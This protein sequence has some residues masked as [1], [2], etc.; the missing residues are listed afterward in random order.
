MSLVFLRP[1][2]QHD[3]SLISGATT[4]Q[5][6]TVQ[7]PSPSVGNK[8]S[9]RLRC[10]GTPLAAVA[11]DV[12]LQTSGSPYGYSEGGAA[13]VWRRTGDGSTSWR[14][15]TDTPTLVEVCHPIA[16]DSGHRNPSTP[17]ELPDGYMGVMLNAT[18]SLEAVY[19]HRISSAWVDSSTASLDSVAAG[20]LRPDFVVMPSGRLMG[21][22]GNDVLYSDDYGVTWT[23]LSGQN[24]IVALGTDDVMCVEVIG[25]E[26]VM[27]C[28][29]STG[30]TASKVAVSRDGGFTFDLA[31]S[32]VTMTNPRTCVLG[33]T[34]YVS[35]ISG[36]SVFVRPV[37][38]G[39]GLGTAVSTGV[40]CWGTQAI[41]T[42]DDGTLWV[43][44]WSP[45]S[46]GN[47]KMS[48]AWSA[49]GVTWNTSTTPIDTGFSGVYASTGFLSL[50]AGMWRD[51]MVVLGRHDSTFG[52]DNGI[53]AL[54]FGQYSTW[55]ETG[56]RT[57]YL[58][59]DYP[60]HLNW[61]ATTTG[62]GATITNQP[63]LRLVSTAGNGTRYVAGSAIWSATSAGAH[64]TIKMRLRVNSGGSLA[65][66]DC[67]L[68]A[69]IDDGVNQQGITVRF[70]TTGARCYNTAGTQIGA[71]LV[72]DL[73]QWTDFVIDFW[74]DYS[75][76]VSGRLTILYAQAGWDGKWTAWQSGATVAE[77]AG[78]AAGAL[79]WRG[80]NAQS[81]D[82]AFLI[83]GTPATVTT[84]PTG[85]TGRA[86]STTAD[87]WLADGVRLGAYGAGG[88]SADTYGVATRYTYGAD[89][90]WAELRPSR[91]V[92]STADH[93]IW[94]WT[95]D[96][97]SNDLF[98]GNMIAVFGTNFRAASFQ[99]D[100][101]STFASLP[102]N[103][104][105]SADLTAFTISSGG[106]GYLLASA[107]VNWR[108]GQFKSNGDSRRFFVDIG[109]A[110]YEI[111][112]NDERRLYVSNVDLSAASGTATI[113]GD[114]MAAILPQ[115]VQYRYQRVYVGSQYT[116]DGK[117]HLG[118]PVFDRY[119]AP[120]QL[121]DFGFVDRSEP[122][123]TTT[124]AD[125]GASLS[126]RRR[127]LLDTLS[128]QW[129]PLNRLATD[130]E[131]RIADMYRALEGSLRPV[132]L[133]R[134][135][136]DITTLSLVQVREVLTRT[137]VRGEGADALTRIDQLLLREVW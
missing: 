111:E 100:T 21:Y 116:A 110:V 29:S 43:F 53:S 128:I 121:Y 64:R 76:G 45:T 33:G 104:P 2:S 23:V 78:V 16:Y 125:N 5:G 25:D 96:A 101:A 97:G 93:A 112:D 75:A 92:R 129:P 19:F 50:S 102:V 68:Q 113:F 122:N 9:L 4:E 107:A 40:S 85:L 15:Y 79:Q 46:G 74:H 47:M 14:G 28:A 133:W 94:S 108:Q 119:F 24:T 81:A 83:V 87:V 42:R 130:V 54:V 30:A 26:V 65:S 13:M 84:N 98:R 80:Q 11:A 12:M 56:V 89:N 127:P 39:G 67:C 123:V 105:M 77:Q 90:A 55:P 134:D 120:E 18:P 8:G 114:R 60:D 41:A 126:Y 3:S 35:E 10:S 109:S 88:V 72:A 58:P 34:V 82:L 115:F 118:T 32:A 132:V 1:T 124:D 137:N 7:E 37:I 52:S 62:G 136:G 86:L 70:T 20:A 103:V 131:L 73:T 31:D 36:T 117:Y 57:G 17:R 51:N 95:A 38:P 59:F 99:M 63:Y 66:N 22:A 27:I 49:D 69:S 71:D 44:S 6:L 106:K 48:Q 61:T 135:T 91:Q